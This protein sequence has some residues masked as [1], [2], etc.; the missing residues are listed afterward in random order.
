[1]CLLSGPKWDMQNNHQHRGSGN[2]GTGRGEKARA[3]GQGLHLEGLSA[4]HGLATALMDSQPAVVTCTISSEQ[5]LPTLQLAALTG[6]RKAAPRS[7]P[8][9]LSQ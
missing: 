7:V 1:M 5:D 9:K 8:I 2:C 3:G 6:L 4:G